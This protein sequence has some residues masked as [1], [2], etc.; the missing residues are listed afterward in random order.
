MG[1][2]SKVDSRSHSRR[3]TFLN[4]TY[5]FRGLDFHSIFLEDLF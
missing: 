5:V 2:D 3:E 1:D 4:E